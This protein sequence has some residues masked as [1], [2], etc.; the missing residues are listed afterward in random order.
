MIGIRMALLVVVVSCC[1]TAAAFVVGAERYDKIQLE[2]N[3]KIGRDLGCAVATL[4]DQERYSGYIDTVRHIYENAP[5]ELRDTPGNPESETVH[6]SVEHGAYEALFA[7]VKTP[8]YLND[9]NLL[10]RM[11]ENIGA[12]SVGIA[13]VDYEK[14]RFV[15]TM[16]AYGDEKYAGMESAPGYWVEMSDWIIEYCRNG[17]P[18]S[19]GKQVRYTSGI[20]EDA[21]NSIVPIFKPGSKEAMAFVLVDRPWT[22]FSRERAAYLKGFFLLTGVITLLLLLF[23][24]LYFHFRILKPLQVL[25]AEQAR[26]TTELDVAANIQLSLLPDKEDSITEAEGCR[27]YG[28]LK[29]A[30]EVGGD[31][32]DYFR[33]DEDHVGIVIGDVVGKGVPASLFS[34]VAKTAIK[35]SMVNG[36]SPAMVFE[37]ANHLLCENNREAMFATA[38]AGVLT[39]SEKRL[40]YANAGHDDAAICRK[41]AD[42][43][44]EWTIPPEEH[45]IALGIID[46]M[47]YSEQEIIFAPEE[48]L[49]IFTDGVPEAHEDDKELY[50]EDRFLSCLNAADT[51]G[52][53]LLKGVLTDIRT[54]TNDKPQFDDITMVLLEI[55]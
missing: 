14:D 12:I 37:Q 28:L 11:V 2:I 4:V 18:E 42:G 23:S 3:K 10:K 16:F 17:D 55:L 43:S 33:I 7:P 31:F 30:K 53:E 36:A 1:I 32:Y 51:N 50:G 39:L 5:A 13:F 35:M 49:L 48:R 54:Y 8:E 24:E 44:E 15:F 38:W 26:L 9:K 47:P 52:D 19:K 46:G 34:M 41:R 6:F 20:G 45:D 21:L 29:P 25:S 40:V 27:F 22:E